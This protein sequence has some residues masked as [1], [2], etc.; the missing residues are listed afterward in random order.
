MEDGQEGTPQEAG[1]QVGGAAFCLAVYFSLTCPLRLL[2]KR[3]TAR[4]PSGWRGRLT[5]L[6]LH[7]QR[8]A[9]CGDLVLLRFTPQ[10]VFV[11]SDQS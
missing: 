8:S 6:S 10:E 3:R 1:R 2:E 9:G 5:E 7:G 4:S 11:R